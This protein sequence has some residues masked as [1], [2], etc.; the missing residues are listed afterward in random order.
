MEKNPNLKIDNRFVSEIET[1]QPTTRLYRAT[2]TSGTFT[3]SPDG[4][5]E[6]AGQ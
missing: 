2:G 1:P 3:P 4:T 6:F 5:T